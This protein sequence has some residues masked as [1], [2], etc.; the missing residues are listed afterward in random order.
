MACIL[1]E[2]NMARIYGSD[3]TYHRYGT[4]GSYGY[5]ST[6][7]RYGYGSYGANSKVEENEDNENK[8]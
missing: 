7:V 5:G 8:N 1:N 2:P 3:G 6:M 4:Y